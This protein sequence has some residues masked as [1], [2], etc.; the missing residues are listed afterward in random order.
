MSATTPSRDVPSVYRGGWF[1]Q[2]ARGAK[3]AKRN[4]AE[5]AL[6]RRARRVGAEGSRDR[7]LEAE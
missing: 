1:A 4:R 3:R 5:H 7:L 6:A 2:G